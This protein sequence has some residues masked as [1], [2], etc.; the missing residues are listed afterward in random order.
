MNYYEALVSHAESLDLQEGETSYFSEAGSDLD[1]RLFRNNILHSSVRDGVLTLLLRHLEATYKEPTAWV[2]VYLAGSGVSY[3]WA[4]NREPGDLD[5]LI[6]VNY[7]QFRQSNQEYKGWSDKEIASELNQGFRADLYPRSEHFMGAFELTFYVN[8][9]PNIEEIKP[10][11]AYSVTDNTWVV[12][13]IVLEPP[14][15]QDWVS[16]TERDKTKAIEIIKRYATALDQIKTAANDAMRVNAESALSVAVHQGAA[17]FDDMHASRSSAFGPGGAGY[18]D[19]ANYRWQ[20]G[21]QSGV[22]PAMKQLHGVSSQATAKFST[23]TY[24]MELPTTETLLRRS[25]RPH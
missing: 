20:S 24:G 6:S 9:N 18:A 7:I 23:E 11:A 16:A 12:P 19:F 22:V 4:A 8:V 10:Y 2:T 14:V 17:L 3:N 15:N 5:C 21:K 13:P 25:Y 1:P